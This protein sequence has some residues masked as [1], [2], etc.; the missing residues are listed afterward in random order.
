MKTKFKIT[1]TAPIG[2][3]VLQLRKFGTPQQF[4]KNVLTFNKVFNTEAEAIDYL[5]SRAEMYLRWNELSE[6]IADIE[7]Y[8][9]L[10]FNSV[11]AQIQ[12]IKSI[13]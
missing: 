12:E 4:E 9:S 7:M 13:Y 8:G 3:K 1:A 2:A 6:A 10:T 5:K 11:T